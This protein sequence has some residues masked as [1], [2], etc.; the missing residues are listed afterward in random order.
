VGEGDVADLVEGHPHDPLPLAQEQAAVVADRLEHA[1][2]RPLDEHDV[3][4]LVE[5][6]L[7][8]APHEQIMRNQAKMCL[9]KSASDVTSWTSRARNGTVATGWSAAAWRRRRICSRAASASAP[10]SR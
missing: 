10:S 4:G 3:H 5:E 6:L 2:D 1:V 8:G 9:A 7:L